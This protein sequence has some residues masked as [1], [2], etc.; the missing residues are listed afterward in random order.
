MSL[1]CFR[2]YM[3]LCCFRDYMSLCCFRDYLSL[4]CFRDYLSLCCFRDYMSL[5]CF[6]DYMSLWCFRDTC[7]CDVSEIHVPVVFVSVF[8]CNPWG[9]SCSSLCLLSLRRDCGEYKIAHA[10]AMRCIFQ[11]F[12]YHVLVSSCLE[13]SR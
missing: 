11:V 1:C 4:C 3:S 6:R 10:C 7:L 2:D 12:S 13:R 8:F 9:L 5:C